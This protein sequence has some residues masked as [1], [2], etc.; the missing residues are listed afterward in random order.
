MN[1]T[2]NNDS[3]M[4]GA[5]LE[6]SPEGVCVL[7][8]N[9][10]FHY[11][12]PAY[13][14]MTG[15]TLAE[16]NGRSHFDL[17]HPNDLPHFSQ[18]LAEIEH[19]PSQSAVFEGHIQ[20]KE[21]VTRLIKSI[22]KRLSD[23]YW[24][25]YNQDVTQQKEREE[26]LRLAELRFRAVFEQP[27]VTVRIYTPDG[28]LASWNEA[29]QQLHQLGNVPLETF[30]RTYN[31]LQ[32]AEAIRL[33][34][35]ADIRRAFAGEAVS[36][37][38]LLRR[39]PS[40][41]TAWIQTFM[42]P[43]KD[44]AGVLC[45][46]VSLSQN[47][48]AQ[49][50]AAETLKH[51]NEELEKRVEERTAELEKT[52]A[53]SK[54]LAAIIEN[55]SD[56]VAMARLDGTGFYLNRAGR[57]MFGFLDDEDLQ[58]GQVGIADFYPPQAL[59]K[60]QA[61]MQTVLQGGVWSGEIEMLH[62]DGR[63][64]P[65]SEV[66]FLLPGGN[67]NPEYLATIVRDISQQKQTEEELRKAKETAESA[68][69]AKSTFLANMSHEIRTPMNAVIGMTGLL[70]NTPL[71]PK[72]RDFVETIRTSG[73]ALLTI[74]NDILDFSKIEA[75]K[76]DLESQPFDLRQCIESALD[77]LAAKASEKEIE[78]IY[79]MG[80]NTPPAITGDVTRLR[81]I[82]VNLIS[83][84]IKFTET[85]EVVVT[86]EGRGTKGEERG[87][88]SE[89]QIGSYLHFAVRDTGIGIQPDKL[90]RL[91]QPFSQID[92]STTREYGGTGLGLAISKRLAEL[93]GGQ[94]WAESDGAGLGTTFHFT[95]EA[96][97]AVSPLTSRWQ[98]RQPVLTGKRILIVDDNATNR[99]ILN[100]QTQTWGMIPVEA[101]SP[102]AALDLVQQGE[103][104]DLAVLDVQMPG[105]DGVTLATVLCQQHEKNGHHFPLVLLT[106]LGYETRPELEAVDCFAAFLTKPVKPSYLYDVL[107]KAL[108]VPADEADE[109]AESTPLSSLPPHA[110][111]PS[112]RIL[113]AEDVAVNQKFALL[114]L[115][116]MSLTADVAANGLEVLEAVQ[117]QPYDV[118]LMDVQ[119]PKMDGLEATRRLRRLPIP[120]PYIVAMTANAMSGD[121]E[122]CLEAGMD[123]YI[124]KPV[125]LQELQAALERGGGRRVRSEE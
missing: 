101:A 109:T 29:T 89:G 32:D 35:V 22:I 28:R 40:G 86:V 6:M 53:E 107:M 45:E 21:G 56:F 93:M 34:Y 122:M 37:P 121:R 95:I 31:V 71:N 120:Q 84:A 36:F 75:G 12:N 92:A 25:V 68:N 69:R 70:F 14:Q 10:R 87:V 48:T 124:S 105:M 62:R 103:L 5:L 58:R 117:R 83:N 90:G 33:G 77:L 76:L 16:L 118:I 44:Q 98:N 27:L 116:E 80:Q 26:A 43:V 20:C 61:G 85:G 50:E 102:D 96:E 64:I 82:L 60:I 9:G 49:V 42:Y 81:Q 52:L 119:M 51:L 114:A 1:I 4:F 8:R 15:Y 79:E 13:E 125:Y 66:G 65:V 59:E 99:R 108:Q 30:T 97:T 24:V 94:M 2:I 39:L 111:H 110:L 123:D 23:G 112:L 46:V 106:S 18:T 17:L 73:D 41:Q 78:L 11:L 55:T 100:L 63:I 74:I 47:V 38:P 67:G 72:Q 104:F 19:S 113:L 7:D 88:R 91:F 57:R 54:R 3:S 115:E